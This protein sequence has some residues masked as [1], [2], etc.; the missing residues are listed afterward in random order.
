MYQSRRDAAY[1]QALA[2]L[3]AQGLLYR[4]RCSRRDIADEERYPGTCRDCHWPDD[5]PAAL[6]VRTPEEPVSFEDR[7]HGRF[8]Q[9]LSATVGDFIVR[10]RDLLIAYVL[11]VVIDDA[12]QGITHVVRGADLLDNTP[13]Q[14]LLQRL[15]GLPTPAYAHVPVL[16]E[17][18]GAKL[19]KSRRSIPVDCGN[20]LQ[21]LLQVFA[22]LGLAP[23]PE[24]H[25]ASLAGA[26]EW[27]T[28]QWRER[29]SG[30]N[31]PLTL[32]AEQG[33]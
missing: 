16:V 12:D 8:R 17:P 24:L 14:V 23:P 20:P 25:R 4:C 29:L 6:R 1:R 22:L 15:L 2:R 18:D 10:R 30:H 19:A 9:Q 5:L 31:F 26:W 27:A 21:Q 7:F 11:A 28:E 32:A 33:A 13:H 3:D